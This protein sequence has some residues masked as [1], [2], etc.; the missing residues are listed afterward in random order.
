MSSV[1]L[2]S[3][4]AMLIYLGWALE[5]HD[6][7]TCTFKCCLPWP[8]DIPQGPLVAAQAAAV[9]HALADHSSSKLA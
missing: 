5:A 2:S 7:H 6:R 4:A 1:L 3:N 9:R 8:V